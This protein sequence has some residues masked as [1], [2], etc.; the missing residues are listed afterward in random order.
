MAPPR[1]LTPPKYSW[2]G[3][4]VRCKLPQRGLVRSNDDDARSCPGMP[5][6]DILSLIRKG[7]AAMRVLI[8]STVAC[9]LC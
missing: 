9:C 7:A 4:E 6:V 2:V 8:T 5:A 3:L 1:P